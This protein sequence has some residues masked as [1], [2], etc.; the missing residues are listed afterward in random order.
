MAGR[1]AEFEAAIQLNPYSEEPRFQLAQSYLRQQ[2]FTRAAAVL[3]DARK[4]FDKSPQLELALGVT[5]YGQREFDALWP[6][7]SAP[8]S[9]PRM[10]LRR[11]SFWD[12]FWST[13]PPNC[14]RL[15][16]C[17]RDLKPASRSDLGYT[18]HAKALTLA[19]P[20]T[21]FPPEA[22]QSV[23]LIGKALAIREAS[24]EAH[25]LM[26]TLFERKRELRGGVH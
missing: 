3:Q 25:Y 26:G 20:P 19:L 6:S 10:F 11:I 16:S 9:L 22:E 8:S 2:D 1:G 17:S 24:A 5:Y 14:L 23:T 15:R 12:E 4:V 18:L 21:G 7:F 13:P